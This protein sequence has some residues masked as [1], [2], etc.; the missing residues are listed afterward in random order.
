MGRPR[1]T[2]YH[3]TLGME[4][5][6]GGHV[7][8]YITPATHE[9]GGGCRCLIRGSQ[10]PGSRTMRV[11]GRGRASRWVSVFKVRRRAVPQTGSLSSFSPPFASVRSSLYCLY[12]IAPAWYRDEENSRLLDCRSSFCTP[13]G[14]FLSRSAQSIPERQVLP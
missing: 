5:G 10:F 14:C 3:H 8:V 9:R 6:S 2:G 4:R 13:F 11:V 7:L 1:G 12:K